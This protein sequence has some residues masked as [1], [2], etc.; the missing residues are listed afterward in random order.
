MADKK[1]INEDLN[2]KSYCKR[3]RAFLKD[4]KDLVINQDEQL[5]NYLGLDLLQNLFQ[6][7]GLDTVFIYGLLS[8]QARVVYWNHLV[9]I[10]RLGT[11]VDIYY[12]MPRVQRMAE[13][14]LDTDKGLEPAKLLPY[15]LKLCTTNPELRVVMR[16]LFTQ[17]ADSFQSTMEDLMELSSVV[18]SSM[19]RMLKNRADP[20]AAEMLKTMAQLGQVEAVL[21]EYKARSEDPDAKAEDLEA[22]MQQK[23]S[24]FEHTSPAL[25]SQL[26]SMLDLAQTQPELAQLQPELAQLQPELAQLQ[27]E[28]EQLQPELAQTQPESESLET[29]AQDQTPEETAQTMFEENVVSVP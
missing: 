7:P 25:V 24:T 19:E 17:G 14:I 9:E 10:F 2:G 3:F 8:D 11:A 18:K 21:K 6:C 28:L 26:Q 15:I 4:K 23:M 13:I 16:D 5:H 29:T 1:T 22:W 27:P 20:A 12:G